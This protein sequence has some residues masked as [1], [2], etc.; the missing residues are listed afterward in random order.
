MDIKH[1]SF[2][3]V[4]GLTIGLPWTLLGLLG[5]GLDYLSL[6]LRWLERVTYVASAYCCAWADGGLFGKQALTAKEY[7]A[8]DSAMQLMRALEGMAQHDLDGED[9]DQ[10]EKEEK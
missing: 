1:E 9:R 6:G 7:M 5:V 10:G 3:W 8:L 4:R 2:P